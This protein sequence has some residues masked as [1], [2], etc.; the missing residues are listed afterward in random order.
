[1]R[2]H[3]VVPEEPVNEELVESREIILQGDA[4]THDELF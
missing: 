2:T 3:G 4:V 1:M